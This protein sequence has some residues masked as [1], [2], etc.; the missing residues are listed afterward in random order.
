MIS[1]EHSIFSPPSS[2]DA[3][4]GIK[5]SAL[6]DLTHIHIKNLADSLWKLKKKKIKKD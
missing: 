4:H 3:F 1:A 6:P 2:L 5:I